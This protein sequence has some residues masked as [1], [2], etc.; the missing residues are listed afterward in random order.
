MSWKEA[1][2]LMT[3]KELRVAR[4]KLTSRERLLFIWHLMEERT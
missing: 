1:Y 2:S 4:K 3:N